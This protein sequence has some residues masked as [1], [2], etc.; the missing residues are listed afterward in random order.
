MYTRSRLDS[1]KW[2]RDKAFSLKGKILSIGSRDDGDGQGGFYRNYFSQSDAYF[3]SEPTREFGCDLLVDVQCMQNIESESWDAVFCSGVLEHVPRP[4]DAVSEMARVLKVGGS[5]LIG[6]PFK[7]PIHM[8]PNDFWRFTSFGLRAILERH[9]FDLIDLTPIQESEPDFPVAYWALA[10]KRTST[11][12]SRHLANSFFSSEHLRNKEDWVRKVRCFHPELS[13]LMAQPEFGRV[14]DWEYAAFAESLSGWLSGKR[15]LDVGCG[16]SLFAGFIASQ[17]A[18]VSTLD[19]P[20]PLQPQTEAID[21]RKRMGI[22]HYEGD[23]RKTD[24]PDGSFDLVSSISAIEHLDETSNGL[25]DFEQQTVIALTEMC[26]LVRPGG[27]LF[28]TSDIVDYGRQTTDAW[29][30]SRGVSA[31]Y[32]FQSFIRLFV[33]TIESLGFKL[34]PEPDFRIEDVFTDS[35]RSTYRGRYFSTF[36]ILAERH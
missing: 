15:V 4:E 1:N 34:N 25:A 8:A 29:R 19:L 6:V 36:A 27:R 20:R 23:M 31:A 18:N 35:R 30:P 17:G 26:R 24:F 5:L 2:I 21:T 7:Q 11:P 32:P 33:G 9:S 14:R 22:S 16:R 28:I 10:R 12:R 3:T 13:R